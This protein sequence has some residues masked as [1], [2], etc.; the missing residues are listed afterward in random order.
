VKRHTAPPVAPRIDAVSMIERA[1][2]LADLEWH[3]LAITHDL[4]D[5][6]LERVEM[7]ATRCT[8]SPFTGADLRGSRLV[9][10]QFVHCECSG[11]RFDD[12][13]ATR[14]EFRDCRMSG[15]LFNAGR[16][17]D[18]RFVDCRIDGADFRM[19]NAERVWFERCN[20]GLAEFRSA[21]VA[22]ARFIDCD[23][24]GADFSQARIADARL[25]G[26]RLDGIRGVDGL[27]RPI[28]TSEQA[29]PL[30]WAVL[31][32]LGVVIDDEGDDG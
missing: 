7:R 23:L 25:H 21:A 29:I 20:L 17:A 9:D 18:V 10:V 12:G 8:S 13:S 16:W 2:L 19:L 11:A 22:G 27:Q 15:A 30:A 14:V 6:V 5:E 32:A 4:S 31:G 28:I 24:S 3:E 26:S 1:A